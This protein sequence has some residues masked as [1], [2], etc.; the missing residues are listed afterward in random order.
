M[1]LNKT[2]LLELL[3]A[4]LNQSLH[5]ATAAA[6]DARDLATHEQSKPET[7]YDTVGLEASYLAH[8]QSLRVDELKYSIKDWQVLAQKEFSDESEISPGAL[9]ELEREDGS[10]HFF[11]LGNTAGGV[12]LHQQE[13]LITVIT[14]SS[15]L[16]KLILGKYSG[17]DVPSPVEPNTYLIINNIS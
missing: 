12:K 8:G 11:L 9:I 14:T 3:L 15:P 1:I 16:G 10:C 6:N 7:Q 5:I 17:D 4:E 2:T 13:Q